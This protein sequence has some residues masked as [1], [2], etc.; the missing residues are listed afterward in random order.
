MD[1]VTLQNT[2]N[3]LSETIQKLT[4]QVQKLWQHNREESERLGKLREA[5]ALLE[6]T[7]ITEDLPDPE[8]R[9]SLNSQGQIQLSYK[10]NN[11]EPM[12]QLQAKLK[13]L[14][15]SLA[16]GR[17]VMAKSYYM[18]IPIPVSGVG[19][20]LG[21]CRFGT[22]PATSVLDADIFLVISAYPVCPL[23]STASMRMTWSPEGR[24]DMSHLNRSKGSFSFSAFRA[25]ST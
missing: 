20:Q 6:F 9:V 3:Q 24:A 21:T 18:A 2:V 19:H 25:P 23:M 14:L 5:E 22:D 4:E 12:R 7:L 17:G 16:R 8:N 1:E 11:L 10:R 15:K 13:S